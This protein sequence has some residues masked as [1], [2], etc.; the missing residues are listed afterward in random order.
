MYNIYNGL[1]SISIHR[2]KFLPGKDQQT[3]ELFNNN[4]FNFNAL[5]MNKKIGRPYYEG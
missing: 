1:Q 5:L 3:S 4:N 2:G